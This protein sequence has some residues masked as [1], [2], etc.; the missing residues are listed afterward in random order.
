LRYVEKLL[1]EDSEVIITVLHVLSDLNLNEELQE[2]Y[3]LNKV[4]LRVL[5]VALCHNKFG[6]R[7][8]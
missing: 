8:S 5:R 2:I 6:D 7:S 3:L 1:L 4:D